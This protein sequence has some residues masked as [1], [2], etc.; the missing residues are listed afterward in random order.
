MRE[1]DRQ[2][3]T[4][5]YAPGSPSGADTSRDSGRVPLSPHKNVKGGEQVTQLACGSDKCHLSSNA[6][7]CEP[8]GSQLPSP[9]R[10]VP[11]GLPGAVGW[12]E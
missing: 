8:R 7:S 5:G 6:F 4:E 11:E 3:L 2:E 9:R 12:K 10:S 1:I